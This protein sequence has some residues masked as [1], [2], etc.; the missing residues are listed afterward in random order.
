VEIGE[1]TGVLKQ[2]RD[3]V[4]KML[5]MLTSKVANVSSSEHA[6][7]HAQGIVKGLQMSLGDATQAFTRALEV[8]AKTMQ[9]QQKKRQ[10]FTGGRFFF[11]FFFFFFF[12]CLFCVFFFCLFFRGSTNPVCSTGR[13]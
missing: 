4:E 2:D 5:E 9:L 7:K 13:F 10:A 11:F 1:L 6:Q 12:V 8:R 3:R